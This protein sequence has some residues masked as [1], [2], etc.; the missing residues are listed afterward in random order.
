MATGLAAQPPGLLGP[1][2]DLQIGLARAYAVVAR[3][4]WKEALVRLDALAPA[5]E[6]LGRGRDGIKIHLLRALAKDRCGVDA[7]DQLNESLSMARMWGLARILA[8]THP[9]LDGL[10]RQTPTNVAVA[11]TTPARVAEPL[12]PAGRS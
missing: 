11:T 9:D 3:N 4:D 8:D 12:Q 2:A 10:V 6:R 5:A 7:T 1:I